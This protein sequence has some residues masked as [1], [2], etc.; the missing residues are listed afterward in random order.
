VLAEPARGRRRVKIG[1]LAEALAGRFGEHHAFLA[2]MILIHIDAISAMVG[3]LD[4]HIDAELAPYRTQ[5]ELLDSIDGIDTRAARVIIADIGVEM[6]RFPSAAQLASWAGVCPATTRPPARPRPQRLA[7]ATAGS[8]P[9][10][11]PPP[12]APGTPG[13][14]A[15]RGGQ[16]ALAAVAH[17]QL[18]TRLA[19]VEH[20]DPLP[21]PRR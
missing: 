6:A 5:V 7:R 9:P 16:R 3:E 13:I 2:R 14:A 4:A 19:R 21:G 12:W 20:P 10:S 15:R 8:R 17:S 1:A 11:A 18:V